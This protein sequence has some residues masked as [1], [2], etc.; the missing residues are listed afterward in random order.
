[1]KAKLFAAVALACAA[2][3]AEDFPVKVDASGGGLLD[4]GWTPVQL[5]VFPP[6]Q[7]VASGAAVD[8]FA[9]GLLGLKQAS[10][11]I[12]F[13]MMN[14]TQCND[15]LQ[16]GIWCVCEENWTF[17]FAPLNFTRRN[18]G[19]CV[20]VVNI[21]SNFGY[22]PTDNHPD[23]PGVQV[24]LFNMG[25]G[26]QIGLLNYNPHGFLKWFPVINFRN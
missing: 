17:Q 18:L 10:T 8:G 1:M 14:Q 16:L 21:E 5:G 19:T 22:R 20:G 2:T 26:F 11:G 15:V 4:I 23:L 7:L 13:A 25:G 24:G 6:C 12:S 9:F 3:W